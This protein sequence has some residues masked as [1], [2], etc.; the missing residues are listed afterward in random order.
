MK[1]LGIKRAMVKCKHADVRLTSA[2]YP[3]RLCMPVAH[4]SLLYKT[5]ACLIVCFFDCD[6]N[7][8]EAL[9]QNSHIKVA[10]S[11]CPE[12]TVLT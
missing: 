3:R 5:A 10:A 4:I 6:K 2:P 11:I 1:V 12:S 9:T 7:V 8:P